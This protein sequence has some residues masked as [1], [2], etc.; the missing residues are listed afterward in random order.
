[1]VRASDCGSEGRGFEPLLPPEKVRGV[2][3]NVLYGVH[4][5]FF[6]EVTANSRELDPAQTFLLF[7]PYISFTLEIVSIF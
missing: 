1:M 3:C 2:P 6:I 4:G 5:I 7:L